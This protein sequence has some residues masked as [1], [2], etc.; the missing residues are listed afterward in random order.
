MKPIKGSF[1]TKLL[2]LEGLF[3]PCALCKKIRGTNNEWQPIE[4][5]IQK[6]SDVSFSH[7]ICQVCLEQLYGDQEWYKKKHSCAK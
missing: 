4:S 3:P 1:F 2:V 5:Y 7:G 6:R